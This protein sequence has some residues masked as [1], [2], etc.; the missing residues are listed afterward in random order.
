MRLACPWCGERSLSEF[1]YG[2]DA[3]VARPDLSETDPAIWSRYVY[4]RDNPRGVQNEYW[5]HV[6][7]CRSWLVVRRD[8]VMHAIA[9]VALAGAWGRSAEP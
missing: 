4:D 5:Q 8:T 1:A 7:G 2:G 9:E 6:G 3:T